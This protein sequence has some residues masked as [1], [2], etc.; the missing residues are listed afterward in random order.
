[1]DELFSAARGTQISSPA[2]FWCLKVFGMKGVL[3]MVITVTL[4]C[5]AG[6]LVAA[7]PVTQSV[8]YQGT[9]TDSSGNPLTGTYTMTFQLYDVVS[10]GTALATDT[11]SVTVDKGLFTTPATFDSSFYDGRALWL[12]IKVG[13][14]PEMTPRQEVRPVPY[15]LNLRVSAPPTPI[16]YEYYTA[17]MFTLETLSSMQDYTTVTNSGDSDAQVCWYKY[18]RVYSNDFILKSSY[19]TTLKAGKTMVCTPTLVA[20]ST[21]M[22]KIKIT[23]NS[24]YVI[25]FT[26]LIKGAGPDYAAFYYPG[27]FQKV[28][29]YQ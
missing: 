28:E 12:G 22:W 21:Y 1:V 10:G 4:L 19:C 7:T 29:I 27:D 5:A 13:S 2:V 18:L 17:P 8:T 14:D 16:R 9:L 6:G 23:T 25:P 26:C 11:H 24:S 20:N 3:F 15:A